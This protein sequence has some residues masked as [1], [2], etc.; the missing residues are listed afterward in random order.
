M[1]NKIKQKINEGF[2]LIEILIVV[3][4]MGILAAVAIPTYFK[5]VERGYASDARVQI[6]NLVENQKLFRSENDDFAE[7]VKELNDDGY[8]NVPQ[9]TLDKWDFTFN[10][11]YDEKTG[12]L[13]G[14]ISAESKDKMGGGAGKPMMYNLEDG[15]FSGYGTNKELGSSD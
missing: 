6:K 2:T 10:L 4:I 11:T 12:I 13:G 5:Y 1:F 15:S 14:D 8:G 9:S 3:V 7:T